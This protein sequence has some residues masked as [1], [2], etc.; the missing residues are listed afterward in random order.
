MFNKFTTKSQEAIIN[1]QITAQEYGQQNIEALHLLSSLLDQDESLVRPILEKAK[2]DPDKVRD[3]VYDALEKIPKSAAGRSGQPFGEGGIGTV[4]GSA[5]AAYVLERAKKEADKMKDEF[6]STE[7]I[8]LALIGI[9]TPAQEI[10][11][12]FGVDYENVLKILN[13]L[14]GGK[15]ITEPDPEVKYRVLEKYTVDLTELAKQKKL[16]PVIGRDT[17]IRRIMQ[18][19]LRRTKNNPVLI[20]DAGTGKTAIVEGLAQKVIANDVPENL[21]NKKIVSLD[22]GALIAGAKF[23]GEFEERLKAVIKEIE[24]QDGGVILFIDELHTLVGAGASEGAMDAS[25]MLKPAL[26]R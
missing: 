15:N 8:L 16:D 26:A 11:L 25:N 21:R 19:L 10:L 23:R 1:A 13:E 24:S 2:I 20:G 18:V 4:S 5:E 9:K 22:L 17:E 7:H 14:R 6:I 12:R 3:Q